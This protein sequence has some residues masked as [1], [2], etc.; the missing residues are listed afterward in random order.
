[1]S[2]DYRKFV[3]VFH[4]LFVGSL[5][6]YVGIYREH[7]HKK[8][9]PLLLGLGIFIILYHLYRSFIRDNGAWIN[10]LHI[11]LFAPL[12]IIIGVNTTNT[13][14]KYYELLLMAGMASFGYH[15]YYLFYT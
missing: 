2:L 11:F 9:Y 5:F 15:T 6:M 14:R 10:Y 8:V 1:M 12:L 3:N 13:S 7:I 4:I